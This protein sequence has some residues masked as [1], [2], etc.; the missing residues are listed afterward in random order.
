MH[1]D[2][3]AG[4]VVTQPQATSSGD[5]QAAASRPAD[6]ALEAINQ[7]ADGY[8]EMDAEYRYQQ[9]NLA[10]LRIT[11]KTR[12]EMVGKH[13][14]EVFP[15][16]TN[17]AIHQTTRR[18][19]ETGEAASVETYYP[20]FKRWYVNSIYPITGGIA[21]FTRDINDQKVLEHNLAF[22]AE[23]SKI[24]SSSLDTQQTL[25][26]VAQIAV[27][28]IADWCAI[29][30]L[31]APR[32]VELLAV[33]HVDPEKVQWAEELRRRDPVDLDRPGGLARV[34]L[35]GEPEF[36]PEVTDEMLVAAARDARTLALARSLGFT[37]A[38]IVPLI[39][40]DATI[41]AI[42]FV[43]TDSGRHYTPADLNMAQEL[44]SRAALAIENS[45]LYGASQRAVTLRDDFIAA[46]SHEL[47]TP[48]TSLKVYTEVMLRQATKR[49]D[50]TA[51]RSLQAMN[52]QIDRLNSLIVDLLDV[53]RIES[54]ALELRQEAFDF[55]QLVDEI[56]DVMQDTLTRHRLAVSGS[57][58][59]PVVGDRERLGQVLTNLLSNAVKYS[60][61]ANHVLVRLAGDTDHVI[62]EVED[63]GIGIAHEHLPHLFD[64]F[65]RVSTPDEKT[66]PG[67][68]MGLYIVQEIVH[69]HGGDLQVE[70][71][72]GRG[73]C[74]RVTL[75]ARGRPPRASEA[76]E[77]ETA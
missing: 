17:A 54:G 72:A 76:A 14:L 53:A 73:S 66:F 46:A 38:M 26:A 30:V 56:V 37:S 22:L 58:T 74:F 35:T 32:T 68:G 25:R 4:D 15:D 41:G 7:L 61:Q 18:V 27:P 36:Y 6:S 69:R 67:L 31:T 28:R 2:P 65:Y 48:V 39:V 1:R 77:M 33:A 45:R 63:F 62:L 8:F 50:D 64:R 60:P 10:G 49:G 29:D 47:R 40:Q 70:S 21:L 9:V 23:A 12:D 24:L 44:A 20:P 55:R 11:G 19:M 71:T 52:T 75:P 57:A 13:V 5:P 43:A 16:I 42:T 51:A 3:D 59:L 34:L